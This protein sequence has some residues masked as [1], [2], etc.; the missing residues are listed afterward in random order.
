MRRLRLVEKISWNASHGAPW[1]RAGCLGRLRSLALALV[2]VLA[3]GGS[4]VQAAAGSTAPPQAR[5]AST[6]QSDCLQDPDC[7]ALLRSAKNLS[8]ANQPNAALTA[9][10]QA[11]DRSRSLWILINI[12]RIQQ[13]LGR[14]ADAIASYQ[15][16]LGDAEAAHEPPDQVTQVRGYQREAEQD[17][18]RLKDPQPAREDRPLYKKW[19]FW[20]A[21]AGTAAV[22]GAVTIG[23]VA[24]TRQSAATPERMLSANHLA[25]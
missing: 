12:G 9:Y 7:V 17:L 21:L 1:P 4:A 20:T 15:K 24:A 3:L 11:Y 6:Q 19:W 10:Q 13:K 25:F 23:V 2:L 8:A 22:A 5:V 14:P 16:Y 18:L